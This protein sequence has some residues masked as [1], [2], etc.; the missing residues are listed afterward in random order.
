M[1][2]ILNLMTMAVIALL[3]FGGGCVYD[4]A[5]R[6][7]ADMKF[8]A[9]NVDEVAVLKEAPTEPYVVIADFQARNASVKY[10]QK[11]AADIGADAVIVVPVGG[12]YARDEI[13]ADNDKHSNSYSRLVATAIKYKTE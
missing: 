5:N 10:I 12:W 1:K 4:E 6:Y 7:Y 13:W 11:R 9:K 8:P 2:Q 3:L